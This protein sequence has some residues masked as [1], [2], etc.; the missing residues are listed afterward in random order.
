MMRVAYK[1]KVVV[2]GEP[3]VGKTTLMLRYTEKKFNELYI[4]TVGVQVSV[5]QVPI[6]IKKDKTLVDLN[7]WDIAGHIK[8]QHIRKVFYEGAHAFL[9]LYDITNETTFEGTSYW[10]GDIMQIIGDQYG[11]LI[12]NKCDLSKERM[13]SEETGEE[14]A[15]QYG[16]DFYETSAKTGENIEDVFVQITKKLLLKFGEE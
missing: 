15:K 3:S 6:K 7:I 11:I 10:R 16:L 9:L 8:F 1:W 4:P 12:G 14:R 5:K 2:I 13:V